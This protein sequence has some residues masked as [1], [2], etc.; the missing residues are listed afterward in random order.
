MRDYTVEDRPAWESAAGWGDVTKVAIGDGITSIGT[1]T[2]FRC[3]RLRSVTFE[4]ACNLIFI[5]N[6]AFS[7]CT[8]LES[9]TFGSISNITSIET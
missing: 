9:V 7:Y 1:G 2:F 8:S 6:E 4:Q 5:G 3:E